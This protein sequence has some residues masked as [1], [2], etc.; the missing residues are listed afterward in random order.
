[1]ELQ[2]PALK[3]WAIFIQSAARTATERLLQQ[4]PRA[5]K[6]CVPEP[7]AVAN[8]SGDPFKIHSESLDPVANAPGSDTILLAG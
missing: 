2:H 3:R 6:K 1:M 5:E 7:G 4:S 8:G